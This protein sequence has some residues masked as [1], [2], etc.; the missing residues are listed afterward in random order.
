MGSGSRSLVTFE[1]PTQL[2]SH[3]PCPHASSNRGSNRLRHALDCMG[4]T[5]AGLVYRMHS[6]QAR[7]KRASKIAAP[8][9]FHDGFRDLDKFV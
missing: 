1:V 6:D 4:S 8:V 3:Q 7:V 5:P 9:T 2:R